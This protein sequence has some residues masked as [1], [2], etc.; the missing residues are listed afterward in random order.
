M[1]DEKQ[2]WIRDWA[3]RAL[4]TFVTH[5]GTEHNEIWV[6]QSVESLCEIMVLVADDQVATRLAEASWGRLWEK[7]H[8]RK[9]D[10]ADV[11]N[12]KYFPDGFWRIDPSG[13]DAVSGQSLAVV[14]E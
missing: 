1:D 9:Y 7:P 13:R 12:G 6:K 10:I 2:R 14:G 11:V 5:E 8:R 3:E 4:S